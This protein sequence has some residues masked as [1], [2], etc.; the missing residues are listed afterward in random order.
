MSVGGRLGVPH[1]LRGLPHRTRISEFVVGHGP[2]V[3]VF[4]APGGC[5]KTV[6]AAQLALL[7]GQPVWLSFEHRPIDWESL[8]RGVLSAFN[9]PEECEFAPQ[10]IMNRESLTA[11]L[12]SVLQPYS[13]T[14]L[15]VVADAAGSVGS[16]QDLVDFAIALR[17]SASE[18][19][20]LV[21]TA[22][23]I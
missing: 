23:D 8:A 10:R 11:R 17:A 2:C 3:V 13:S 19:S 1:E 20:M 14:R 22:S 21:V 15:C 4:S 7:N 5:G 12:A 9:E 6:A 18:D 16:L